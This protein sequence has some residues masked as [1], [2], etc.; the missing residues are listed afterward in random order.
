MLA[1]KILSLNLT[2]R[3]ICK[4]CENGTVIS[5]KMR[6]LYLLRDDVLSP[7]DL[8][9]ELSI[10]K[11]NLTILARTMVAEGLIEKLRVENDM[12]AV[13]Y[14]ITEKGKAELNR[15]II[16]LDEYVVKKLNLSDGGV[17]EGE[18]ALDSALNLLSGIK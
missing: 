16:E 11:P 9:G 10:A 13:L 3:K 17:A 18:K 1:D 14:K 8:V 5:Q 7:K 4:N 2:T 15:M 6:L 12:R